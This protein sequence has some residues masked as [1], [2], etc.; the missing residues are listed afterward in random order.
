MKRQE[1]KQNIWGRVRFIK[2]EYKGMTGVIQSIV[3]KRYSKEPTTYR[4][5]IDGYPKPGGWNG[6]VTATED[7]IE[8][9]GKENPKGL[10][11]S[12]AELAK[13][14][15][16]TRRQIE[17]QLGN[18]EKAEEKA[19]TPKQRAMVAKR[20]RSLLARIGTR[21]RLIAATKKYKVQARNLNKAPKKVIKI[22]ARTETDALAEAK[23]RLGKGFDEFKVKNPSKGIYVVTANPGHR[24]LP[25]ATT[26]Q[27]RQYEHI[28]ESEMKA[29]RS[30]KTSKSIAAATVRKNPFTEKEL[31]YKQK[32]WDALNEEYK[33]EFY[34]SPKDQVRLRQ[35]ALEMLDIA[36]GTRLESIAEGKLKRHPNPAKGTRRLKGKRTK[37]EGVL[38]ARAVRAHGREFR[39]TQSTPPPVQVSKLKRLPNRQDIHK[40]VRDHIR[41]GRNQKQLIGLMKR[42]GFDRK[43]LAE[44]RKIY[45]QEKNFVRQMRT[46]K[47]PSRKEIFSKAKEVGSKVLKVVGGAIGGALSGAKKAVKNPKGYKVGD[48]VYILRGAPEAKI[49]IEQVGYIIEVS[50]G[51]YKVKTDTGQGWFYSD[52][53]SKK[54]P[55]PR[56]GKRRND[57]AEDRREGFAGR[58]TGHKE[59]YFPD[60]TPGGLST[61]GPVVT[62]YTDAGEFKPISGKIFLSQDGDERL[63]AGTPEKRSM[64]NPNQDFGKV[65]RI[66]Y[67][68]K[69]PHLGEPHEVIWFH[70]FESPLPRLKSDHEGML[71]FIGGGY[72]IKREGIVG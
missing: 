64:A 35:I 70:D 29:G 50:K 6:K 44:A 58:V 38:Y 36:R 20:K 39:K 42:A 48:K 22:R 30:K 15:E 49:Y 62:L 61:L 71:H 65:H 69:K 19:V 2:G 72:R 11:L 9:L 33:R 24:H 67:R 31:Q 23:R 28:L 43:Y 7:Q 51:R 68:C 26:K 47:N 57:G 37:R 52:D 27:Q 54:K 46:G 32:Q 5:Q 25:G 13:L 34:K 59:L 16:S 12:K 17:I 53:V 60:G 21:L 63:Y 45:N 55:N 41:A 66:E 4:I 8:A 40:I 56:K 10:A 18:V 3:Q 1:S 14:P